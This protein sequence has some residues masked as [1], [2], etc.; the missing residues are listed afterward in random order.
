MERKDKL[1]QEYTHDPYF[2]KERYHDPSVCEKC[3]V[4]YNHGLF[5]WLDSPPQDAQRIVCPACRRIGDHYEGGMVVL[6]GQFLVDHKQEIMNLISNVAEYKT[7]SRPLERIME[8]KDLGDRV[9]ITTTYEHIARRIAEA[10]HSAYKG[11]LRL[12][13]PEGEKYVRAYWKRP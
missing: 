6:E 3:G 8:I 10:V 7:K 12:Q 11:E 4:V 2:A 13:Y 1:V 9:E 5:E